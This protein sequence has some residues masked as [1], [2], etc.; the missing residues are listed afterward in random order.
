[1]SGANTFGGLQVQAWS[2]SAA[3]PFDQESG[4]TSGGVSTLQPGSLTPSEDNCL[5]ITGMAHEANTSGATSINGG[6]TISDGTGYQGGVHEGGSMAYLVQTS[7]A[8]ANPTWNITNATA[9]IGAAMA[10]F[11]AASGGGGGSV[12]PMIMHSYRRRRVS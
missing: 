3:S 9:A 10:V 7:A 6:F 8:A 1:V 4:T 12:V 5:V 2:G 11:K